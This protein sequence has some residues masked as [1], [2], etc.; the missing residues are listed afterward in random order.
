MKDRFTNHPKG[1]AY[2]SFDT[3]EG[4]QRALHLSGV[5][6]RNRIIKVHRKRTNLPGIFKGKKDDIG[7]NILGMMQNFTRGGA[8]GRGMGMG[9]GRGRGGR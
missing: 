6:L 2:I 7:M 5:T 8:R 9:M 4:V 1:C 3:E